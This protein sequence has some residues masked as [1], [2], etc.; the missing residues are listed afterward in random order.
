MCPIRYEN[1]AYLR[2][3]G[4]SRYPEF[5]VPFGSVLAR[6]LHSCCTAHSFRM[7]SKIKSLTKRIDRKAH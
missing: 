7:P 2:R 4:C 6:L 1:I 5:S 3:F